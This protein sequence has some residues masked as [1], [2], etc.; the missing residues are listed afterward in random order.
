M[1]LKPRFKLLHS[2]FS[3][4]HSNAQSSPK[5]KAA[6]HSSGRDSQGRVA[7]QFESWICGHG[8]KNITEFTLAAMSVKSGYAAPEIC[9]TTYPVP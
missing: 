8:E 6:Q 4:V 2:Y 3:K 1:P 7:W 5:D 9:S